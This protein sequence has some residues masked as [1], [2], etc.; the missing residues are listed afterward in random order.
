[1]GEGFYWDPCR[2]GMTF[3]PRIPHQPPGNLTL[4]NGTSFYDATSHRIDFSL[5]NWHLLTF[6]STHSRTLFIFIFSFFL[7]CR[8]RLTLVMDGV[9]NMAKVLRMHLKAQ[10]DFTSRHNVPYSAD[11]AT[12]SKRCFIYL[13]IYLFV[14]SLNGCCKEPEPQ[15]LNNQQPNRMYD[16]NVT[17]A[18]YHF[19]VSPTS[20]STC[21]MPKSGML[22]SSLPVS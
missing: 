19:N 2:W 6:L 20:Q 13:F 21:K 18:N 7:V 8:N 11:L 14:A 10:V 16:S 22:T 3:S 5:D 1:M 12:V 17:S 15:H 4:P 9:K